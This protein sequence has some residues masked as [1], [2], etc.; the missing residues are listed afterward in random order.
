M[1]YYQTIWIHGSTATFQFHDTRNLKSNKN[2]RHYCCSNSEFQNCSRNELRH[3]KTNNLHMR[4][5]KTQISFAV[6]A[7]LISRLCLSRT[8]RIVQSTL[9][10]KYKIIKPLAI[11]SSWTA[12]KNVSR[13]WCRNSD[14]VGFLVSRSNVS[15]SGTESYL[16]MT[17][18]KPLKC[19]SLTKF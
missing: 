6:T 2:E 16:S 12:I 7:K 9:L 10:P 3:E 8:S 4:G 17:A 18:R 14:I 1:K 19:Q 13:L 15:W 5:S 11:F